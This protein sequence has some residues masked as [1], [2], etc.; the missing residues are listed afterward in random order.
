MIFHSADLKLY[1]EMR[2]LNALPQIRNIILFL[3]GPV[4]QGPNSFYSH[5]G[6]KAF[7]RDLE[8]RDS[9]A[10]INFKRLWI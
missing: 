10:C 7:S 4:I 8:A 2:F 1:M 6:F 3:E 9:D 5:L